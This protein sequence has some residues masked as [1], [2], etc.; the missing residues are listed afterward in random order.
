MLRPSSPSRGSIL[1][2]I[3]IYLLIY[4]HSI[5]LTNSYL[6]LVNEHQQPGEIIFN[7]SVYKLGSDRHYKISVQRSAQFVTSLIHLDP[8]DGTVHLKKSLKCN[9]PYYPNLFTVHIDSTSDRIRNIEYYS[10]PLRIFVIGKECDGKDEDDVIFPGRRRKRSNLPPNK[11]ITDARRWI[12]E[13]YA[14]FAIPTTDKWRKICLRQSQFINSVRAF[15]P[16]TIAQFCSVD[17]L[18]V[19]DDRFKIERSQGDLVA[20]RD[21]CISEPLWKVIVTFSAV[22]RDVGVVDSEHRLKIVYH[23]QHF[24]DTDIAHRV[25]R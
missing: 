2:N 23:H 18:E 8:K 4:L 6:L 17:F 13:T 15:L 22:C 11:R 20:S 14:S 21:G 10:L 7:A 5:P 24:N 1:S 25:R 16:K 3:L 12:S 19:S 9:S